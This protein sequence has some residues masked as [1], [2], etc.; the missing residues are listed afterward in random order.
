MTNALA[1]KLAAYLKKQAA[2]GG[3]P[4]E[5]GA[6]PAEAMH[7]AAESPQAEMAEHAPGGYEEGGEH[8]P[9]MSGGDH[10]AQL[11]HLLSQLSPEELEQLA[12]ELSADMQHPDQPQGGEDV[13]SLAHAIQGHLSQNPEADVP[14]ASPEKMA[15][16]NFVKSAAYIEGFIEQALDRG[17]SVKQAVDMYDDALTKTI[18]TFKAAALTGN[19]TKL[20]INHNGKIDAEDLKKLRAGKSKEDVKTAAYYE[21]VI[22]RAREY[23]FSDNEAV[24][25]VKSALSKE[26][27]TMT[28]A[29][30]AALKKNKPSKRGFSRFPK[31]GTNLTAQDEFLKQMEGLSQ[32]KLAQ[33]KQAMVPVGMNAMADAA[34]E[35][36]RLGMHAAPAAVHAAPAAAAKA[37]SREAGLT[38]GRL[39][40]L[41]EG[42]S[43][44][45][46]EALHGASSAA[47]HYK[48][49]GDYLRNHP[50]EAALLGGGGLAA[51]GGAGYLLGDHS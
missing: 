11:E 21:G 41:M 7:E 26:A 25:I 40:R 48:A 43:G 29:A 42:L 38:G 44:S 23:G 4:P 13:A 5:A 46:P 2:P 28:D 36:A 6:D 8:L 14:E 47:Q 30:K 16:L 49:L 33:L 19:Q 18:Q 24:Q 20:D 17:A 1:S 39:T 10:D 27:N 12:T 3:M 34:R 15:A 50:G 32:H 22:E 9:D 45:A 37:V 35:A 31:S 51:A